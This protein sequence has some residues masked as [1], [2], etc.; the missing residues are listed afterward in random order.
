M[1]RSNVSRS[2]V[3]IRG[4]NGIKASTKK[5]KISATQ[6]IFVIVGPCT[7][8]V[9]RK[10][11]GRVSYKTVMNLLYNVH[12]F[13]VHYGIILRFVPLRPWLA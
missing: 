9:V 1:R 12:V 10:S 13:C 7:E 4:A 8:H 11:D 3:S 6:T 5:L 2:N